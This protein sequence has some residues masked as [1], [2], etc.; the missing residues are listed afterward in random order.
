MDSHTLVLAQIL[1]N[2]RVKIVHSKDI[3]AR[4]PTN[5]AGPPPQ[6]VI[7]QSVTHVHQSTTVPAK[8]WLTTLLIFMGAVVFLAMKQIGLPLEVV[9]SL[10]SAHEM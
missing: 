5:T 8:E 4:M 10:K 1:V 7:T 6:F 2:A 3:L 9:H